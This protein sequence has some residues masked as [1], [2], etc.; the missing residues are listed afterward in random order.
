[1]FPYFMRKHK[2]REWGPHYSKHYKWRR[3]RPT[4]NQTLRTVVVPSRDKIEAMI[5]DPLNPEIFVTLT[6]ALT[7]AETQT[8][9]LS[10]DP[11]PKP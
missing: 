2:A 8:Q 6:L 7:S 10:I 5:L 1:M 4:L 3:K 9:T 11:N